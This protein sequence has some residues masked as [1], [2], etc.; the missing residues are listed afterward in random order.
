MLY[1]G[2]RN[3]LHNIRDSFRFSLRELHKKTQGLENKAWRRLDD[4]VLIETILYAIKDSDIKR[5]IIKTTEESVN[6][7]TNS[8]KSLA[9]FGDGEILVADGKDIGFQKADARLSEKLRSILSTPQE[10]LLVGIPHSYYYSQI[11]K[12]LQNA[13]P[14]VK[15][16]ALYAEPV[17]RKILD[18]YLN[19]EMT[20]SQTGLTVDEKVFSVFRK[21]FEKKKLVLV[22]CKE[23]FQAY[24]F[25]IFD[26]ALHFDYEFVPNK[27]C[28]S[29]YDELLA[30]LLRYEKDVLMILMCGPTATVLAA[31]L[32]EKGFQALDLG[33]L[34]KAYDWYKRGVDLYATS[35]N[36]AEFFAPD[37]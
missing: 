11:G 9:R 28:F 17:L 31:D 27:H 36:T 24:K 19:K 16:F 3:F 10:N 32:A 30:R 29:V 35:E 1:K 5:P 34:A 8:R 14:T 26:S 13:N 12:T 25:N 4:D 22:G 37:E 20:F 2:V 15:D 23:A 7:I 18:K 6:E 33:H 21:F